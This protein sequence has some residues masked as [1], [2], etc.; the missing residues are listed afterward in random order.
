VCWIDEK[1]VRQRKGGFR[2][3][4]EALEFGERRLGETVALRRGD[5]LPDAHRPDTVDALLGSTPSSR[6]S[7]ARSTR[8]PSASSSASC[9]RREPCSATGTRTR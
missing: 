9:A 4:R 6:S 2:T 1:G 3:E 7:G 5:R 8:R